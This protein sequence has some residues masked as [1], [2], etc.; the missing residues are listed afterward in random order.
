MFFLIISLHNLNNF[1]IISVHYLAEW[2]LD[3]LH[4]TLNRLFESVDCWVGGI[5]CVPSALEGVANSEGGVGEEGLWPSTTVPGADEEG[6]MPDASWKM[7]E[8]EVSFQNME[9]RAYY[10]VMNI[11]PFHYFYVRM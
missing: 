1:V 6:S 9:N 11:F 3:S 8:G 2:D 4:A 7:K 10:T 5:N